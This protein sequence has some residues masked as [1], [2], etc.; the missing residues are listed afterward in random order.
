LERAIKPLRSG[1]AR[2]AGTPQTYLGAGL[3]AFFSK[4]QRSLDGALVHDQ[5]KAL[6]DAFNQALGSQHL[7]AE[8]A[9]RITVRWSFDYC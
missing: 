5:A 2:E 6:R 1:Y 3:T 7:A 8:N 9:N 4:R